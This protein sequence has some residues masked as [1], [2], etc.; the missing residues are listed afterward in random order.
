MCSPS[1][2]GPHAQRAGVALALA[3]ALCLA[4]ALSLIGCAASGRAASAPTP[5]RTSAASGVAS[6][7]A[8]WSSYRDPADGFVVEYPRGATALGAT[9]TG[10]NS[11]A[12][13][14][15]ANPQDGADNATLEVTAT[16][17]ANAGVCAHYSEGKP[18]TLRGGVIGYEQDNLG[19]PTPTNAASQP[20]IAVIALHGG[21]LTIIT[22]TG[23]GQP[24]TFMQRWGS[25]WGHIL[26]TFQP[27]QGPAGAQPC[28]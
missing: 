9:V 26:A 4:L 28:G 19:A 6:G 23:Q 1:D 24:N 22:L 8:G 3:V 17:Q 13:W 7:V 18:L 20:Q 15:I 27:G 10:A 11:L 16:T 12:S 2:R 25:I 21:L 14:R 5:T